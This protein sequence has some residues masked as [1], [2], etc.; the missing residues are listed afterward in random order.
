MTKNC[1]NHAG[2]AFSFFLSFPPICFWSCGLASVPDQLN[3]AG[4]ERERVKLPSNNGVV[5]F[6][7]VA[8]V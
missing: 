3:D 8:N 7:F 2:L 5:H 1:A 4:R 6:V